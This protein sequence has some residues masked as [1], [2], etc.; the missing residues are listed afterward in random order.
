P[1]PLTAPQGRL[2][3]FP[4]RVGR[5]ARRRVERS[6]NSSSDNRRCR[7][8]GQ[9]P[10]FGAKNLTPR[11]IALPPRPTPLATGRIFHATNPVFSRIGGA[12]LVG[13]IPSII[14]SHTEKRLQ[15]IRFRNFQPTADTAPFS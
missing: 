9:V 3:A 8:L 15:R 5:N 6:L 1:L 4:G 7:S 2:A 11:C 12:T 13:A 14:A 10:T